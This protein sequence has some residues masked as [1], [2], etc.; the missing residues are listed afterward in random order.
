MKGNCLKCKYDISGLMGWDTLTDDY[1]TCPNC[2][3][4]MV[5]EYDESWNEED[6]ETQYWWLEQYSEDTL[7]SM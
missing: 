5:V 2:G 6:G 7:E 4:K 1:I 3:N